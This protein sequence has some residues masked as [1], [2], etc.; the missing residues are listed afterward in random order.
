VYSLIDGIKITVAGNSAN[1]DISIRLFDVIA[2]LHVSRVIQLTREGLY[3]GVAFHR[4][5]NGFMAQTGDVQYGQINGDL[6]AAG[7]GGSEYSDLEAEFSS[8]AFNR[9]IVGMARSTDPDSANSQFFMMF[10]YSPGLNGRYTVIGQVVEGLD[11]L[12]AIKRG[13]S[14]ADGRIAEDPDYMAEVQLVTASQSTLLSIDQD[15]GDVDFRFVPNLSTIQNS[16]LLAIEDVNG[17][18]EFKTLVFNDGINISDAILV[19]KQIVGI[20]QLDGN[21]AIAADATQDGDVNISDAV[22]ILKHIVGIAPIETASKVDIN[23]EATTADAY[24]SLDGYTLVYHGDVD[25]SSGI[26]LL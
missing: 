4:V 11:V 2:P 14:E 18:R 25:L 21:A 20:T 10:A 6:N 16:T 9:S 13:P 8:I 7:T 15:T 19:L 23:G 12:D 3:D 1:G 24:Q 17:T 5:I 26:E 22:T